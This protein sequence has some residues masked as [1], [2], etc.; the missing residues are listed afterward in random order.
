MKDPFSPIA[1]RTRRWKF[2]TGTTE[3]VLGGLLCSAALS[4]LLPRTPTFALVIFV[5]GIMLTGWLVDHLQHRYIYSRIGYVEYRENTGK[6]LWRLLLMIAA[7][8]L[9]LGGIMLVLFKIQPDTALA[10]IT[11]LLAAYIGVV[12]LMYALQTKLVRLAL[13]GLISAAV[14]I[15][16]VL[17]PLVLGLERTSGTF[18]LGSLGFYFLVMGLVF[19]FSGGCAFRRFLR[20]NPP[21]AE[22]TDGQ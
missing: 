4:L 14:A 9:L 5:P 2:E 18:G 12:L 7:S 21:L 13:L 8:L 19:L 3:L 17:S 1:Q 10:W 22:A 6:G 15:G 20:R 11:S 16:L